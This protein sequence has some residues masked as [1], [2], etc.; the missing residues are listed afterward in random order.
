[1]YYRLL[2]PNMWL[3]SAYLPPSALAKTTRRAQGS[4]HVY[5][6]IYDLFK[7]KLD[8][9]TTPAHLPSQGLSLLQA[10]HLGIL[11]FQLFA[12][13]HLQVYDF[14]ISSF[15]NSL[16]GHHLQA[17]RS[18]PD[19]QSIHQAWFNH[20]VQSLQERLDRCAHWITAIR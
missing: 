16:L 10:K 1:M 11:V 13:L 9:A 6:H 18:L 7:T 19:N 5:D 15:A 8:L 3:F 17:W 4:L 2:N 20:R 14:R 12:A